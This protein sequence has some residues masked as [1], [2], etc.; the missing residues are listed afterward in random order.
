MS[1]H[2]IQSDQVASIGDDM[3]DL[4]LFK[5]SNLKVAVN[6]AHPYVKQQANFI[7]TLGGGKGAVREFCDLVLQAKGLLDVSHG[8][9]L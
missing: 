1:Q 4:G 7:T 5:L 2:H 3:P 8:A 9:S 6:D